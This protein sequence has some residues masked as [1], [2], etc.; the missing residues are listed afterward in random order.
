M[1]VFAVEGPAGCGKTSRLMEKLGQTLEA[2][3][4]ATGQRVL[5][6]TFMHGA[7]RRLEERLRQT[8]GLRGRFQCMTIDSFAWRLHRR[9][10]SLT[11]TLELPVPAEADFDAQCDAAGVLLEGPDV[12]TWVA[13]SF[14]IVVVDEAQDLKLERL[15]MIAALREAVTLLIAADEFQCLDTQLRQ[16]PLEAWL[17]TVCQPEVL[18]V[19]RRTDVPALL[20]AANAIRSG[21]TPTVGRDF[22]IIPTPSAAMA[23]AYLANAIAWSRGGRVAVIT[24]SIQGGFTRDV[25]SRVCAGPCG[26]KRNGPYPIRWERSEQEE[27]GELVAAVDLADPCSLAQAMQAL[28][29]LPRCGP[30]RQT[31]NWL[32]HQEHALGRLH[33][34]RAEV[35]TNLARQVGSRRH[36]MSDDGHGL[37]AMTVQQAKNREFDGVVLIWP[38]QVGGDAEHKRR[39]LYNAITRARRWCTVLVQG[40]A[41]PRGAPFA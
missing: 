16:N 19:V 33:F 10:R 22:H 41:L 38:Y 11:G 4:L 34:S 40:R 27:T 24:P 1:T 2:A 32:H 35:E 5:A 8:Y 25:V 37:L 6:L 20:A 12:R 39:L 18:A 3:P 26:Q 31:L 28:N 15:R 17:P 21:A 29:A 13:A 30:V 9:W 14:P 7:R 36:R 23:A